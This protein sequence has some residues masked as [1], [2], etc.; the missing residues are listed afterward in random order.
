MKR[1]I[2]LRPFL[3][4]VSLL[5]VLAVGCKSQEERQ[6]TETLTA[7]EEQLKEGSQVAPGS[8]DPPPADVSAAL[9]PQIRIDL[10]ADHVVQDER[11]DVNISD[12]PARAFLM[13]LVEGTSYNMVVHP[14]VN[15]TITLNL[16]AVTVPEVMEV[17]RE[18]YGYE[19]EKTRAGFNVTP[20]RLQSRIF[21]IDYLNIKRS[22]NSQTRV[23]SG[24][25]TG[26]SV[27]KGASGSTSE[28][29]ITGTQIITHSDSD[30]WKELE[31]A[32]KS[33]IGAGEGRSVVVTPQ[34]GVV[35]VRAMPTELREVGEYLKVTQN[36]LQ[37]QVVIEAKVVEVRL[38]DGSQSGINW[39]GL[40]E[41]NG[42]TMTLGHTGGGSVFGSDTGLSGIAGN[43]GDLN[44]A[45]YAA[46]AA[47]EV[48]A[49]GGVF[50]AALRL[51]DFTA[52][53]D[54]LKSEGTVQV[55]SSPRIS[56]VNNQKAVIKV[57]TDEFF[58][59]DISSTT[60]TGTATTTSPDV[61]LT[62]FFS[63]IALDVI[64]RI[65]KEGDVI[66]HVHPAVSEVTDQTKV[67]EVAGQTQSLPLAL[68]TVR[69]SD[70]VIKA[71][72]G[73]LVV[74]GGL[75]QNQSTVQTSGTPGLSEVPVI[76]NLFRH[77]R[78]R[79]VKSELVI[80]L[81]PIVVDS[82]AAWRDQ[83]QQSLD[84]IRTLSER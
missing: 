2:L 29:R 71:T 60:V 16:K 14:A 51:G 22:G 39:A 43:T 28:E 15:G 23:S 57:G 74:I 42:R 3:A 59:T 81:R 13:G 64:P 5:L 65:T 76:G 53:I 78:D 37:R 32:L 33:I 52:F 40:L 50:S 4:L 54:L 75:M 55:L 66:L 62:P 83:Q 26:T 44:P 38:N 27:D 63:G 20:A 30:F 36:N 6:E 31:T 35:V 72:S 68:S 10:G 9:M 49:F 12:A 24:Q 41:K 67:I 11:F 80:L 77:T 18:V 7:I 82:P 21:E 61:T 70:S 73:Q 84:R 19:Y 1:K 46:V 79:T 45:D 47:T 8:G 17:L 25:I 48:A 34:S 58:V 56:T 69:E